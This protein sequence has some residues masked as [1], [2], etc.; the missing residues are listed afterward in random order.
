MV[1]SIYNDWV[2]FVVSHTEVLSFFSA[3]VQ[4]FHSFEMFSRIKSPIFLLK[5]VV[6]WIHSVC[7]WGKHVTETDKFLPNICPLFLPYQIL[8]RPAMC[9]NLKL[10]LPSPVSS[11]DKSWG[12][13]C[14]VSG[15]TSGRAIL[16]GVHLAAVNRL[17]SPLFLSRMRCWSWSSHCSAI[18]GPVW[19]SKPHTEDHRWQDRRKLGPLWYCR[20]PIVDPICLSLSFLLCEKIKSVIYLK[21]HLVT[22]SISYNWMQPTLTQISSVSVTRLCSAVCSEGAVREA[23]ICK[24]MV[25]ATGALAIVLCCSPLSDASLISICQHLW[26]FAR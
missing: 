26:L 7:V 17:V 12:E 10:N 6:C 25:N 1:A 16:D 5:S 14:K 15:M 22:F 23:S 4:N 13:S 3:P 20:T 8:F 21:H 2:W 11:P 9:P 24:D 18:S 19:R